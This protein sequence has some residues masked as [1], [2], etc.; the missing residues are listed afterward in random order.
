MGILGLHK[1]FGDVAT[2]LFEANPETLIA[3]DPEV[4]VVLTQGS[5]TPDSVRAALR[6]R[7]GLASLNAVRD[8]HIIAIPWGY[9]GPGPVAG[10]SLEVLSDRLAALR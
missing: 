1:I 7:P 2:R 3:R 10:Q 6:D 9:S 5:Q 4:I 8:D